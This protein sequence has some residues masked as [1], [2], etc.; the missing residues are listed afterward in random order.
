MVRNLIV[1]RGE[2]LHHIPRCRSHISSF[3]ILFKI[4]INLIR[5]HGD[6]RQKFGLSLTCN[7]LDCSSV[8]QQ[9]ISGSLI[10]R[11][12]FFGG[13]ISAENTGR[14]QCALFCYVPCRKMFLSVFKRL[15]NTRQRRIRRKQAIKRLASTDTRFVALESA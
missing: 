15:Q 8:L 9:W 14:V 2:R 4:I 13:E 12:R 10:G 3:V 1:R 7:A 5:R 6:L 11:V